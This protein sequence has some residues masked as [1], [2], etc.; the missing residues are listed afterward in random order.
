MPSPYIASLDKLFFTR[1]A[2]NKVSLLESTGMHDT[3]DQVFRRILSFEPLFLYQVAV[4]VTTFHQ[5][6]YGYLFSGNCYYHAG[7]II[8]VLQDVYKPTLVVET[9]YRTIWTSDGD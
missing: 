4:L 3:G 9:I 2:D 6:K 8:K 7:T 1:S 5:M